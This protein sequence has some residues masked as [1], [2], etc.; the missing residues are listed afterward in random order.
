MSAA[1]GYFGILVTVAFFGSNFVPLKRLKIGDGVFFQFCMCNAIFMTSFPVL[2]A[3]NF[4][5]VHGLALLGGFLWCTGN[6]LCPLAIRLVGM[7]MG[8]LVWGCV[9]MFVGWASGTFGLFGLKKQEMSNPALNYVGVTLA[10]IG[11]LIYLQVETNDTSVDNLK[12]DVEDEKAGYTYTTSPM[13]TQALLDDHLDGSSAAV[14]IHDKPS[15][16]ENIDIKSSDEKDSFLDDWSSSSKRL[17]GLGAAC[18]AGIFFGTS[19]DPSQYVIDNQYDGDDDTLNYVFPHY[20]G[21]ILTSWFYTICYCSYKYYNKEEPYIAGEIILPAT[22]SGIM[23]GIAEIAWFYANGLLGF[24]V[25]FPIVSCGPGFVGALWGIFLFKEITGV[26]NLAILAAA[27]VVTLP[28][29]ILVGL[30]H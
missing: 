2:I 20:C 18:V 6:M 25:T 29:L 26:R 9:G 17:L 1:A 11:L 8:L 24:T 23:W 13:S 14:Y 30:S 28:G 4:P 12:A 7:G 5:E 27:V 22:I 3:Q 10:F 15:N 16:T 19:F 21:I